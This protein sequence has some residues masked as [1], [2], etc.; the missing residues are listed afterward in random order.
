MWCK[1]VQ[2]VAYNVVAAQKRA[3]SN[4]VGKVGHTRGMKLAAVV[5]NGAKVLYVVVLCATYL[6][7]DKCYLLHVSGRWG[8]GSE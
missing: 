5:K 1:K 6:A 4:K 7:V 8:V 2:V 3:F